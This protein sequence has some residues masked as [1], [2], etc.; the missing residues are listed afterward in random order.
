MART[1]RR[2]FRSFLP[3][4]SGLGI[5]VP[6]FRPGGS[7][8]GAR[9]PLRAAPPVGV[10]RKSHYDPRLRGSLRAS[11]MDGMLAEVVSVCATGSVLTGWAL[12][13][14]MGP[15]WVG[16]LGALPFLAEVV[17]LPTAWVTSALG[18]RKVALTAIAIARSVYLP[19]VFLPF[20]PL[21]LATQ[22]RV[23]IAVAAVAA[24]FASVGN[25]GWVAWMGNLVP[26][27]LRGRYFG[28]RAALA[29]VGGTVAALGA[30][31]ALDFARSSKD[32]G[33]A[34]AALAAV[35]CVA[36]ALSVFSM[37]RQHDPIPRARRTSTPPEVRVVAR[38]RAALRPLRDPAARRVLAYQ[39]AWNLAIGIASAFFVVYMLKDLRLGF[40]LIAVHG[41][42]VAGVRI[43]TT[44]F[45]G[46]AVDRLGARPILIACSF[47]T[48]VV[49]LLWLFIVPGRLWLLALDCLLAGA[50][51]CGHGIASF[52]LP[53]AVAPREGRPHY[54]AAF[55]TAGGLAFACGSTLG[56]TI[57]QMLPAHLTV[58]GHAA[59]GLDALFL[60]SACGRVTAA[61]LCTRIIEPG[62]R[63]LGELT[64]LARHPLRMQPRRA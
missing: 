48:A 29:M 43:L 8:P 22:Q 19:L 44:R 32:A 38:R 45:W 16:V 52:Q 12:Y 42:G 54:L 53:L 59:Y 58:L 62:A 17:Q 27:P 15:F 41:A 1:E 30:G 2:R 14:K 4:L 28:R 25:N 33:V 10:G 24:V 57:A 60:L 49:P 47:G 55:A 20:S 36:G 40:F 50:L 11:L 21:T 39:L 31:G 5:A 46:R 34:F 64:A 18:H 56:G 13:L 9:A 63:S 3:H 23:L 37:S 51:W 35:A 61:C 7:V 6:L 26:E